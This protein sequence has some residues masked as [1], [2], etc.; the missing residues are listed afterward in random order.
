MGKQGPCYHCGIT[1]TPLWRNGP[2]EKPVLCNACGSRWRTK[3]TLANYTPMHSR[4]DL[5]DSDTCNGPKGKTLPFRNKEEKVVMKRKQNHY[6]QDPTIG[7]PP[8]H[9]HGLH[10]LLV[11]DTSNRSSSGSA[12]S[13]SESWAEFGG[14]EVSDMTG[15]A[16]PNGWDSTVP[17]RKRTCVSR[18]KPSPVEKLTKDLYTILHEQQPFLPSGSS[19]EDLILES[20]RPNMVCVEIGHGSMLIQHP[21]AIGR[22]EESEA[23]CLSVDNKHHP[24]NEA[25]SQL[26]THVYHYNNNKKGVISSQN[27]WNE[28]GKKYTGQG[29][30]QELVKREKD[31]LEEMQ[32]LEHLGLPLH[33][34]DLKGLNHKQ[35]NT[36]YEFAGGPGDVGSVYIKRSRDEQNQ[37]PPSGLQGGKSVMKSP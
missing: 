20:D 19:E 9:N 36:C 31:H 18:P 5:D 25:Y 13:N 32:K 27:V 17:C 15:P 12:V 6:Q 16:Q 4:T 10:K 35:H 22:E 34:M 30:E 37:K 7:V 24:T 14:T 2:P 3:G 33:Y 26:A 28:R 23:S 1:S 21:L 11:E 8:D 29:S